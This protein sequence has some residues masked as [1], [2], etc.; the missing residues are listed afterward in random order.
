MSVNDEIIDSQHKQILNQINILLDAVFNE[1][2]I[3]IIK[4]LLIF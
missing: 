1:K 2:D 3:S 4:K